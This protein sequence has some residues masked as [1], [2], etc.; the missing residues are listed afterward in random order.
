M[1]ATIRTQRYETAKFI[2]AKQEA[3]AKLIDERG[4]T[5]GREALAELYVLRRHIVH[6]EF[7]PDVEARRAWFHA[8]EEM[9]DKAELTAGLIPQAP[10]IRPRLEE[11][12][13]AT[14]RCMA[15]NRRS[16]I[17]ST[18]RSTNA[19][20]HAIEI[21]QAFLRGDPLPEPS[22][23]VEDVRQHR[24]RYDIENPPDLD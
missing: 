15:G 18:F 17:R 22:A 21:L 1:W 2:E 16:S 20:D 9:A 13:N 6:F 11:A 4:Q 10:E 23:G 3:A 14:L 7:P 19:V 5:A 8:G 12:L 24:A